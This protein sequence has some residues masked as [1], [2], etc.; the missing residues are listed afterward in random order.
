VTSNNTPETI[1]EVDQEIGTIIAGIDYS[2][3][4]PSICVH[5][6]DSS[7]KEQ[8]SIDNCQ[9]YFVTPMQKYSNSYLGGMIN[10]VLQPA[11]DHDVERFVNTA[12]FFTDLVE[13][14]GIQ[15][16][17]LEDYAFNAKGRVF[18]LGENCGTLKSM[19]YEHHGLVPHVFAPSAIKKFAT[20]S[21]T[22]DKDTMYE[23]F[24]RETGMDLRS[25]ISGYNK[26]KID[27]PISDIVDSYYVCKYLFFLG[28]LP[29]EEALVHAIDFVTDEE[30]FKIEEL[31]NKSQSDSNVAKQMLI[32]SGIYTKDGQ[33]SAAY[34]GSEIKKKRS[35]G[36]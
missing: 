16:I 33:L 17:G 36:K 5:T 23:A 12:T 7:K 8:F 9:F 25:I 29:S 13:S 35:K 4:G 2:M 26:T 27:S 19:L 22:A 32:D 21:G 11:Y 31:L 28:V 10:G 18:H 15:W 20:G 14:F 30:V 34:G 3:N 6:S 1:T 24:Y